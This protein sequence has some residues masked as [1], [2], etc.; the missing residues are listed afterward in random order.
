MDDLFLYIYLVRRFFLTVLEY[1]HSDYIVALRVRCEF[2]K[3]VSG[4]HMDLMD[5]VLG[6]G[7]RHPM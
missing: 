1:L 4:V 3:A 6:A 7:V 5:E 2:A